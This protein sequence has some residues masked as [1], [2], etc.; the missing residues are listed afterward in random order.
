VPLH[1]PLPEGGEFLLMLVNTDWWV[2]VASL[3]PHHS[4]AHP[5]IE[6]ARWRSR[7]EDNGF[8]ILEQ[9]TRPATMYFVC[10]KRVG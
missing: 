3:L 8:E 9:G 4:L 5:A 1:I 10:R 6:I 7:L 2:R